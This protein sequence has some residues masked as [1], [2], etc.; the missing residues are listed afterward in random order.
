MRVVKL[1]GSLADWDGLPKVLAALPDLGVAVVPGGGPFADQVRTAQERWRFDQRTAHVM[2]IQAMN[3]YGRMLVALEPRLRPARS[4]D[5]AR[6]ITASGSSCVWLP[7][8]DDLADRDDIP[9]S[10][11]VTSDSLAAWLAN[12][13]DASD[14]I[15]LKSRAVEEPAS[16]DA[17]SEAGIVDPALPALAA[18]G[19]FTTWICPRDEFASLART[20][21]PE[22]SG[23]VR[24]RP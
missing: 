23:M 9:A 12:R 10:W 20:G 14:L 1:G 21:S 15:L 11:D 13:I 7:D 18:D 22:A 6:T 24:A 5:D 8:P 19:R 3:Q 16:L 2:A 4:P 17:L